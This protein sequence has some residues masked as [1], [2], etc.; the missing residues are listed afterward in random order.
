[1]TKELVVVY[2]NEEYNEKIKENKILQRIFSDCI[3]YEDTECIV[4]LRCD[5]DN[6]Y[7][8]INNVGKTVRIHKY[9]YECLIGPV[10]DGFELD[11]K[12]RTRKCFNVYHLEQ[13]THKVNVLRGIGP[14]AIN[15]RKTH[16]IYGHPFSGS[17]LYIYANGGRRCKIC[18]KNNTNRYR[19]VGVYGN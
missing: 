7:G 11:H 19:G 16:C 13:V 4:S 9:V 17:N 18:N 12:C 3:F 10:L 2:D 1:M 14:T 6:G 15:A 8:F 5:S